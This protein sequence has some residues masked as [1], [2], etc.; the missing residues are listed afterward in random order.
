MIY[1]TPL[2]Q[3]LAHIFMLLHYIY[4]LDLYNIKLI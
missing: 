1:S 4:L 3:M 2:T